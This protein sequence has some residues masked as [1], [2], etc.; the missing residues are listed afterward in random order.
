M[1]KLPNKPAGKLLATSTFKSLE[2]ISAR[3][4]IV[5][6]ET[7]AYFLSELNHARTVASVGAFG[8]ICRKKV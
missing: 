1:L 2:H 7:A 6:N 4:R 8:V 3:D 5:E